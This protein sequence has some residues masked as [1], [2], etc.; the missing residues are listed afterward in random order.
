MKQHFHEQLLWT[1]VTKYPK[2]LLDRLAESWIGDG[3]VHLE[4]GG[5]A[6]LLPG[7]SQDTGP[8]HLRSSIGGQENQE[9][10]TDLEIGLEVLE[11]RKIGW[12]V[13]ENAANPAL[14]AKYF[15]AVRISF[16]L[17]ILGK[18]LNVGTLQAIFS[19]WCHCQRKNLPIIQIICL[20]SFALLGQMQYLS[21]FISLR[22]VSASFPMILMVMKMLHMLNSGWTEC[23]VDD[24]DV[25]QDTVAL[26]G[27]SKTNWE[28][29]SERWR[30][31]SS[32]TC[33]LR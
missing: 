9:N 25:G 29:L 21:S 28:S 20:K 2:L 10:A 6:E 15:T 17:H 13:D 19:L 12:P 27:C 14:S 3:L 32:S 4:P 5:G 31:T 18:Y 11:T 24:D 16:I 23:V 7:G 22:Q 30:P 1:R 33:M 26:P 8:G